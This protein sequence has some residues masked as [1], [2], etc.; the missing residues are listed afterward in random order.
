M[1]SQIENVRK[2]IFY[3]IWGSIATKI[4]HSVVPYMN[5]MFY[6]Q[7]KLLGLMFLKQY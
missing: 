2:G 3:I 1:Q 7:K 5:K 6:V 4:F